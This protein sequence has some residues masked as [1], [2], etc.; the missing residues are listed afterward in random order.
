MEFLE[1][2]ALNLQISGQSCKS[3]P[4]TDSGVVPV[5][6]DKTKMV[7]VPRQSGTGT[8]HQNMVGTGTDPSGTNTIA[9]FNPIFLVFSQC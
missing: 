4:I 5:P 9:S 2:R 3:I 1:E 8:T 7:P 6:L